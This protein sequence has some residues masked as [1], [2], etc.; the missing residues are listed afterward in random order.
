M[1]AGVSVVEYIGH[2]SEFIWAFTTPPMLTLNEIPNL[3]NV[4][5]PAVVSQWGCWNTYYVAPDGFTMGDRFMLGGEHGAVAV[6][7]ASTLTTSEGERG[8]GLELNRRMFNDGV[9][10]GDAL[11]S[12]KQALAEQGEF[13]DIQLGWQILGDPAIVIN[14]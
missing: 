13:R 9:T 7:G 6:L 3:T 1:N 10:I 12:A 14:P 4:G 11:I 8:L 2:S 5:K